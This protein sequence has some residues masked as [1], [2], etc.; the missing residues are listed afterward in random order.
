MLYFVLFLMFII[1]A[2]VTAVVVLGILYLLT[3]ER[4]RRNDRI[5][6]KSEHSKFMYYPIRYASKERFNK[7]LKLYPWEESG[8]LFIKND[9]TVVFSY[10]KHN[11]IKQIVLPVSKDNLE[12]EG[13]VGK[14][15]L[16]HWFSIKHEGFR[17]YFSAD[18][19]T[20]IFSSREKTKEIFETIQSTL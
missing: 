3:I 17:H 19:G 14:N 15:G 8:V 12:W 9:N 5:I 10:Y 7:L 16:A 1:P 20:F 13:N 4:K 2:A 11:T 18:T 6:R